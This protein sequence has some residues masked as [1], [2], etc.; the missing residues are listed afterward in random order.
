MPETMGHAPITS[1]TK[2]NA[3]FSFGELD[4]RMTTYGLGFVILDDLIG[5]VP[6]RSLERERITATEWPIP[7]PR[8]SG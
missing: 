3:A 5:R 4:G 7:S 1:K 2:V 6:C 8:R